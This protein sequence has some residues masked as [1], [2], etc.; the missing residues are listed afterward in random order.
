V[1]TANDGEINLM[2]ELFGRVR[3]NILPL[4]WLS[5][6]FEQFHLIILLPKLFD[7]ISSYSRII[8]FP[9]WCNLINNTLFQN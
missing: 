9:S 4:P 2:E 6:K 8:T 3:M 5:I 1:I 7:C